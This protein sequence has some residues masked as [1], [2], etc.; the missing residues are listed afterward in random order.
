GSIGLGWFAV[1]GRSRVPSPPAITT[2]FTARRT[3]FP[4]ER[5]HPGRGPAAQPGGAP[6]PATPV[7]PG[8]PP[9]SSRAVCARESPAA[10]Q[11]RAVP[12]IPIDQPATRAISGTV[13]VCAPSRSR[14]N[15]YIRHSV[16]V[17]PTKLT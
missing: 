2:A 3:P 5:A 17:L 4:D 15:A 6:P 9:R 16:A 12:Q 14:G 11:Y 8:L 1:I 10:I 13:P 7:W